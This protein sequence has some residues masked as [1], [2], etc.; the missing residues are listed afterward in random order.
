MQAASP[1]GG[2]GRFA[3]ASCRAL[4][5]GHRLPTSQIRSISQFR[6]TGGI[7]GR[8]SAQAGPLFLA[9]NF[10]KGQ[11]VLPAALQ[12]PFGIGDLIMF[13]DSGIVN[14]F[15]AIS[16]P[17][18][19]TVDYLLPSLEGNVNQMDGPEDESK[20]S[21]LA[22]KRTYQPSTLK[23]K[24]RH[25]FRSVSPFM[26]RASRTPMPESRPTGS[27]SCAPPMSSSVASAREGGG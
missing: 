18:K 19:T 22:I 15:P 8:Q 10:L 2:L 3:A 14:A 24:R 9:S 6:P 21:M 25:G 12:A 20:E 23:R 26:Q 4:W 5:Q 17:E 1:A 16:F 13:K 27:A 11:N 7:V